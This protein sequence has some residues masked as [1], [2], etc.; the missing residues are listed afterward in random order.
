MVRREQHRVEEVLDVAGMAGPG[1][2]AEKEHPVLLDHPQRFFEPRSFGSVHDRRTQHGHRQPGFVEF[3]R[4]LLALRLRPRVRILALS[5][6]RVVVEVRRG[7]RAERGDGAQVDDPLDPGHPCG[8]EEPAGT[9][10]V[11]REERLLRAP[12]G[13][14]A[15]AV[16]DTRGACAGPQQRLPVAQIADRDLGGADDLAGEPPLASRPTEDANRTTFADQPPRHMAADEPRCARHEVH[17]ASRNQR[18]HRSMAGV[19]GPAL[20]PSSVCARAPSK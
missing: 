17:R 16:E 5:V 2:A 8:L 6:T 15:G 18:T 4:D 12:V 20:N 13:N 11:H 14:V 10:H 9:L 19:T 1:A 7:G 3:E